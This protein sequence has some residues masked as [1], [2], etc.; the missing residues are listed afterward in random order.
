MAA[1]IFKMPLHWGHSSMSISNT[2][3]TKAVPGFRASGR[4]WPFKTAPGGF[5]GNRA[6]LMGAGATGGRASPWSAGI[7]VDRNDLAT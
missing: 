5:V 3:F 6:Q 2:R 7:G 1:S 4:R